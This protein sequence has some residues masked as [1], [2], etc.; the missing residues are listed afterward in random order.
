MELA[1]E[2]EVL[3]WSW[4]NTP[5]RLHP[6]DHP[7]AWALIRLDGADTALLHAVDAGEAENMR[8]GARVQVRWAAERVGSIKDI[9]CFE[10]AP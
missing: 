1:T 10:L 6:L 7:F 8:T 5:R 9:A 4:V 2:G 3:T